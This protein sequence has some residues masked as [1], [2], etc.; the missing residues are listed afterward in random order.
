[1]YVGCFHGVF[2]VSLKF[3]YGVDKMFLTIPQSVIK[4]LLTCRYGVGVV[5][6][7]C[8]CGIFVMC[9][10]LFSR[11]PQPVFE[12]RLRYYYSVLRA[13]SKYS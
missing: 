11:C 3:P 1:M 5:S 12:E 6:L 7:R 2:N 8:R 10:R 9:L 4:V 13:S